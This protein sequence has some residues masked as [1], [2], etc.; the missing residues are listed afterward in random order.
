[1]AS[2]LGFQHIDNLC[3]AMSPHVS[4]LTCTSSVVCCVLQW[5]VMLSSNDLPLLL[6]LGKEKK[7]IQSVAGGM[8]S[9][10]YRQ[11]GW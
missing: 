9:G 1:M 7:K 6:E 5:K 10:H 4:P 8:G 2:A 11:C 3:F